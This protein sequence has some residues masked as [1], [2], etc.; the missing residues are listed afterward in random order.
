MKKYLILLLLISISAQADVYRIIDEYGN[1]SYSDQESSHSEKVEL[2][3]PS[4]YTPP[5]IPVVIEDIV[6]TTSDDNEAPN[7]QLMITSPSQNENIW[8][9]EGNV[10][11]TVNISP[12]LDT[13]RG[14][15][16][17]FKVDGKPVTDAQTVTSF[18]LINL[19]RGSHIALV[20]VIDKLGNVLKNSKSILFHVHKNTIRQQSVN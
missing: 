11:I 10:T 7:Y 17:L 19:D 16:L 20:S 12:A 3:K 14:D 5:P 4:T 15:T 2:N 8:G 13:E 1:I 6:D 9:T 18:S